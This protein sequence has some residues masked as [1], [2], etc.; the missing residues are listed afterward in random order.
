[1]NFTSDHFSVR[2]GGLQKAD[3]VLIIG[4]ARTQRESI[5]GLIS[6]LVFP[7]RRINPRLGHIY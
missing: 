7:R 1:M 4:L 5:P 3:Q 2:L 6:V